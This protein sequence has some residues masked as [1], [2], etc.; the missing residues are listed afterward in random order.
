MAKVESIVPFILKWETGTTGPGL[1]NE[2]L[3]EKAK[4]RG[5]A[6]DP[7]D[8]GGAT[9]CGVTLATFTEYCR[10]KGYPR[11]T[12]TRL[13]AI[14]YRE[15]LEVLKTL[16]WDRWKA[17]QI[18]NASI[19][20]MLVDFV[21]ASGSYGITVPQKAIG[22][23]ADGV[24]GPKTLAA[25]N[26]RDPRQLFDLLK[27]ERLAYIERI[28]KA[29]PKNYKYRTGWLNRLNDIKFSGV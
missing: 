28:C 5:F 2:Q 15:W 6:N 1:T 10:R 20:L 25:I 14:T 7:D 16:F 26:A 12:V 27:K 24:V 29:R 19:A 13:K 18:I 21:W 17:D 4:K 11:P 23:T 8:L 22:V 9:M 3:F